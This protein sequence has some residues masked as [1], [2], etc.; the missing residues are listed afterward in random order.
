[1]HID[2]KLLPPI[3]WSK[4]K[5]YL[6]VAIDDYSRELYCGIYPDKTAYSAAMFLKQVIQEC[7]YKIEVAMIDNW[8]EYQWTEDHEFVKVGEEKG[9]KQIFTRP[10]RPQ[11]NWN[12]ERVIRTLMEMW[13]KRND[14]H[15]QSIKC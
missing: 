9:I 5:E 15:H 8:R 6:F 12:A 4:K 2:T 10:R 14:L 13:H 11:T 1:M 3:K 7:S